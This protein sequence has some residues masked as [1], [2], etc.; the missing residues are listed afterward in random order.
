MNKASLGFSVP[1]LAICLLS[2]LSS[3]SAASDPE[4]APYLVVATRTPLGLD[5][6]SPS[7]SYV[8]AEE[9]EQW[10]DRSL[11]DV[12]LREPG[13][14][15]SV[16]GT[17]GSTS[18]VFVRGANS[19]QTSIF[20]DGRRM[21]PAFSGQYDLESLSVD[22][23]HSVQILK[24]ASSVNYGSSGIGGVIDLRSGPV[25]G[26]DSRGGSVSGEIGSNAYRRAAVKAAASSEDWGLSVGG[27]VLHT[28]NERDNDDFDNEALY[29]RFEYKLAEALTF[30]ILGNYA[31][32]DKEFLSFGSPVASETENWL[33]SPG[34][35]YATDELTLHGFYSRSEFEYLLPA[36][37]TENLLVSDELSLQ[38]D[39]SVNDE[40]LLTVGGLYRNDE[41]ESKGFYRN[42]AEQH[43]AFAQML[44]RT[45]ERLEVRTGVRY[46]DYT[47]YD[48]SLTGNLE[49][50]LH[51][52]DSDLSVFAK[53]ATS[54]A[55]PSAQNLAYD[56]NPVATPVNPE[57]SLSYEIGLKNTFRDDQVEF[58][59]VAFR[60]EADDLILYDSNTFDILNV[61][62]AT[63]E[64]IEYSLGYKPVRK[65][66][67]GLGYTYLTAENDSDG[68][69]LIRRPRHTLQL[70]ADYAF[71]DSFRAGVSGLGYFDREE[72]V[73]VD[74]EDFFVVRL[75]ADWAI[76]G[77]WTAFA[78][79]EN[80]LDESYEP[81]AGY[82][83]LGRSGYLGLRAEF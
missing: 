28:D 70:S 44:W 50:V 20:L 77:R 21:S 1:G 8:G 80:L 63:T 62:E 60:N 67:I 57:K 74:L 73:T 19:D 5:R 72:P 10:Q 75:V 59:L 61:G 34:L 6:V 45:S 17:P 16:N 9:M 54:Y 38:V 47:D 30:E 68:T 22:N 76:D 24:G 69:R 42:R 27:S 13:M 15:L 4:L 31:A 14:V 23:L 65:L 35:R 48:E 3:M 37:A 39:Y 82:P 18:G 40:T 56:S 11:T 53:I 2:G 7:A 29:S 79:V 32:T 78:R 58:S 83:A 26:R 43:G 52:P 49:V 71:T 25:L 66:D 41:L 33:L 55:P 64:G 36:F 81:V 12:L 51:V 46:D